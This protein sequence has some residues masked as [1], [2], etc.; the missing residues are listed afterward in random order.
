MTTDPSTHNPV[1]QLEL[2]EYERSD[3]PVHQA[4]LD[5]Y[6]QGHIR[7]GGVRDGQIVWQAIPGAAADG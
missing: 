3:N 5:L 2:S 1:V 6:R 7:I 4:L